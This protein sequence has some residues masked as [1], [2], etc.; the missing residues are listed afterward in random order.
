MGTRQLL[1][2]ESKADSV[3]NLCDESASGLLIGLRLQNGRLELGTSC[4]PWTLVEREVPWEEAAEIS[5]LAKVGNCTGLMPINGSELWADCQGIPELRPCPDPDK[6]CCNENYQYNEESQT[7]E[8]CPTS[9]LPDQP[10]YVCPSGMAVIGVDAGEATEGHGTTSLPPQFLIST[11]CSLRLRCGALQMRHWAG[12]GFPTVWAFWE[13]AVEEAAGLELPGIV[14]LG[15]SFQWWHYAAAG[16]GLVLICC[17]LC[18]CCSSQSSQV[19]GDVQPRSKVNRTRILTI[20]KLPFTLTWHVLIKPAASFVFHF[21]LEPLWRRAL[22]PALNRFLATRFAKA[23]GGFLVRL[24]R[25]FWRCLTCICPC[26]RRLEKISAKAT[27]DALRNPVASGKAARNKVARRLELRRQL[28]AGTFSAEKAR[29]ELV[30]Q[31][32]RGLIDEKELGIRQREID[33]AVKAMQGMSEKVS[34]VERLK[35]SKDV[36]KS[37]KNIKA[38]TAMKSMKS[39]SKSSASMSMT[40]LKARRFWQCCRRA[41][42]ESEDDETEV[43]PDEVESETHKMPVEDVEDDEWEYFWE[44]EEEEEVLEDDQ[45]IEPVQTDRTFGPV[46]SRGSESDQQISRM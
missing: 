18:R 28:M 11:I 40:D 32:K 22:R 38:A 23:S 17:C 41:P 20:L 1:T 42:R 15:L 30:N 36:V 2:L 10:I 44:E 46:P 43:T 45:V 7:C 31:L 26:L 39:F 5:F 12:A 14:N 9:I 6:C 27:F 25:L 35:K 21:G 13:P 8:I 24:W 3:D 4:M 19:Y 34:M 37:V 29:E 16:G 33:D